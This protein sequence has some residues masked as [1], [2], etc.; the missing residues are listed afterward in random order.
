MFDGSKS[1]QERRSI[2][3]A[4][5]QFSCAGMRAFLGIRLFPPCSSGRFQADG[6]RLRNIVAFA[7]MILWF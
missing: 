4:S 1:V 2:G 3:H 6:I 7:C 5:G